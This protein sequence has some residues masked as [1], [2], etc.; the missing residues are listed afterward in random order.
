MK[1]KIHWKLTVIFC[2]AM[3]AGL[4]LGYFYLFSHMRSYIENK[5]ETDLKHE[6]W[7]GKEFL[8][9]SLNQQNLTDA[10]AF[11]DRIGKALGVRATIIAQDGTVIGDS[12]LDKKTL[13]TIENHLHRPEIQDALRNGLGISKRY[14][15]TLGKTLAY[16]AVP[17]GKEKKLGYLRLAIPLSEIEMLESRAQKIITVAFFLAFFISLLFMYF[18]SVRVSKPL[19]T[20]VGMARSIARGDYPGGRGRTRAMR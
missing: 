9:S 15:A 6:V 8:E 10:D 3:I 14:S 19:K 13:T 17:F 20:M 16:M 7:L 11:A 5:V 2:L 1:I 4:F 12:D 18:I